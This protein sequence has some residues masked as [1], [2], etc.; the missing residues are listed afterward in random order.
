MSY[1]GLSY[2]NHI[3]SKIVIYAKILEREEKLFFLTGVSRSILLLFAKD[4]SLFTPLAVFL[5]FYKMDLDK[6]DLFPKEKSYR[7]MILCLDLYEGDQD[8]GCNK[9][10]STIKNGF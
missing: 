5:K 10:Y 7:V 9:M 8:K 2:L 4:L 3:W 6:N 1:P